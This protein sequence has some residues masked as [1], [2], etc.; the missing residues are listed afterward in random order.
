MEMIGIM[1]LLHEPDDLLDL[2]HSNTKRCIGISIMNND[3]IQKYLTLTFSCV[4]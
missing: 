1:I 3:E 2:I 4:N